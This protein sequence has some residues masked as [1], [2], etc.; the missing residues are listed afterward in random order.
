[1]IRF[2]NVVKKYG[3]LN[4]LSNINLDVHHGEFISLVGSF[5]RRKIHLA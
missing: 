2:E 4:A 3:Q 1:M 5:G